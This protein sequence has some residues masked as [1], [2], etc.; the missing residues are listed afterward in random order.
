VSRVWRLPVQRLLFQ[1]V[2]I[3]TFQHYEAIAAACNP[4][5]VQGRFL[6]DCVR[7]LDYQLRQIENGRFRPGTLLEQRFPHA[8]R[9]FPFLYEL[10]VGCAGVK[11]FNDQT[12]KELRKTPPVQALRIDSGHENTDS[13]VPFQLLQMGNWPLEHLAMIGIF[14][15]EASAKYPPA[16]RNLC[17]LRLP[18]DSK[19]GRYSTLKFVKAIM[20]AHYGSTPTLEILHTRDLELV[21][22]EVAQHLR[23]LLI[24]DCHPSL[25]STLP[26]LPMLRELIVTL[27]AST[28][29]ARH[30]TALSPF[31]QH[32]GLTAIHAP[33]SRQFFIDLLHEHPGLRVIS[34]YFTSDNLDW[35]TRAMQRFQPDIK[36]LQKQFMGVEFRLYDGLAMSFAA[37][38]T[39]LIKAEQWPRGAY[40]ENMKRMTGAV[41]NRTVQ[42]RYEAPSSMM[43]LPAKFQ[44]P[45]IGKGS[46]GI[47]MF[48]LLGLP[49]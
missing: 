15:M 22:P 25:F 5:T 4:S 18:S 3:Q 26:Q 8:L 12:M 17:E 27:T 30:F 38:Q 44:L 20:E 29:S 31:I 2:T 10:R 48:K 14:D 6:A 45:V 47:D 36:S 19:N 49:V 28:F 32:I 23:S 37:Q 41:S 34:L 33:P 1:Q 35:R 11:R 24:A 42:E 39:D 40:M 16:K 7:I 13:V 9:L 21:T 43:P 46:T